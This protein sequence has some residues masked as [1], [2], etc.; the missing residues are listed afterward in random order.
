[1]KTKQQ[2][3]EWLDKQPWKG[4]FYEAAVLSNRACKIS[5]N[6]NLLILAFD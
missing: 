4:E 1:M 5:Y 6:T 3:L 2:I